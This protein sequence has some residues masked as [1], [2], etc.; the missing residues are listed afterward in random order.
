MMATALDIVSEIRSH[1]PL[2]LDIATALDLMAVF[3]VV[4]LELRFG[5]TLR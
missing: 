4:F 2:I 3:V 1:F 5:V